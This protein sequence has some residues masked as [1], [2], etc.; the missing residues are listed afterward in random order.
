MQSSG[1]EINESKI[2]LLSLKKRG[3]NLSISGTAVKD[4]P[5]GTI[6]NGVL[7]KTEI[8]TQLLSNL[9]K[10]SQPKRISNS[11]VVVTLPEQL[12]YLTTKPMPEISEDQIREALEIN[13][14][15]FVPGDKED[16]FWGYQVVDGKTS[17]EVILASIKKN[18]LQNYLKAISAAGFVPIAIEPASMA[19]MRAF[20]PLKAPVLV[21][22]ID[23][24]S[25]LASFLERGAVRFS[26]GFGYDPKTI[27]VQIKK[28]I[29]FYKAKSHVDEIDVM[30][31]GK[32]AESALELLK[33]DLGDFVK[34][35]QDEMLLKNN[36][37]LSPVLLGSA[38]RGLLEQKEDRNLSLLPVGTAE[39]YQEKRALHFVGGISRLIIIV[40]ILFIAIFY[41]FWGLLIYLDHTTTNQLASTT[42]TKVDP[43]ISDIAKNLSTLEP[44]IA[45]IQKVTGSFSPMA[46]YLT[47]IQSAQ[48]SNVTLTGITLTKASN[49]INVT[50]NAVNRD[51]LAAFKDGLDSSKT[52][53]K[54]ALGSTNVGESNITFTINLSI[55]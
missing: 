3:G 9:K 50:G 30:L 2:A 7:Q 10:E 17:K 44:K 32:K 8:F 4:L 20:K 35:S 54:V 25:V 48:P 27:A 53:S 49:V 11:Y 23:E 40:S 15:E 42:K 47:A 52:F 18:V 31:S 33:T 14:N 6:V 39:G 24:K 41:G 43:Q 13:L 51:A 16:I 5:E 55:K 12:I 26:T 19:A 46:P 29:S 37:N 36:Q 21:L 1:L 28:I 45:Y 34:L 22:E 38:M